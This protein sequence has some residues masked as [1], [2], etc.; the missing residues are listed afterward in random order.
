[1]KDYLKLLVPATALPGLL[2]WLSSVRYRKAGLGARS[3][4]D[5]PG[6]HSD[7][8]RIF[9]SLRGVVGVW[10]DRSPEVR[11]PCISLIS[12]VTSRS[13][14]TRITSACSR[15][16]NGWATT[17]HLM[18]LSTRCSRGARP[19]PHDRDPG[20]RTGHKMG[21]SRD[22]SSA[23]PGPGRTQKAQARDS[24]AL[25]LRVSLHDPRQPLSQ[26][27]EEPEVVIHRGARGPQREE[28][29]AR[30][31]RR[32]RADRQEAKR[33]PGPV[34][35]NGPVRRLTDTAVQ[36]RP[37]RSRQRA[38]TQMQAATDA[39]TSIRAPQL[40]TSET[41]FDSSVALIEGSAPVLRVAT[42][43]SRRHSCP[44]GPGP[45]GRRLS[46]PVRRYANG[47][48][49]TRSLQRLPRRR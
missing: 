1:M 10:E 35:I 11:N 44:P 28:R 40:M 48:G 2:V 22:R 5:G 25:R 45:R 16:G 26:G 17:T 8:R 41:P 4:S 18:R 29:R 13:Y 6:S 47:E 38:K 15:P 3:P 37:T 21:S 14:I 24:G 23:Q 42:R 31:V 19:R 36:R 46:P 34:Q 49:H 32:R 33:F 12:S 20:S 30:A 9:C 39:A 27:S 7:H 43:A